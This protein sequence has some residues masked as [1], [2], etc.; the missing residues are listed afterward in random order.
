MEELAVVRLEE[1][2]QG[3]QRKPPLEEV[4]REHMARRNSLGYTAGEVA[5]PAVR[6]VD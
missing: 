3:R 2:E 6:R 4:D 1:E 5:R